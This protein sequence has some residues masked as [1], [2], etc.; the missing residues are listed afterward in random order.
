MQGTHYNKLNFLPL[1]FSGQLLNGD[2]IGKVAIGF[3]V[4][5]LSASF[6]YIIN[7]TQDVENDRKYEIKCKRPIASGAVSI[8]PSQPFQR[9]APD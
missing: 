4:F 5:S 6:I 9:Q 2:Q 7:D 1:I 3:L 8:I